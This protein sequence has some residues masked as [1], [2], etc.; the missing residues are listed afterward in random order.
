MDWRQ[1]ARRR[2]PII[3]RF[4]SESV[5]DWIILLDAS[6]SMAVHGAAK[7]QAAVQ[8]AA[9]LS[10]ALLELGHRVGL[11]AFGGRVLSEFPRGRGQHHYAALARYLHR[12]SPRA[13]ARGPNSVFVRGTCTAPLRSLPSAISWRTTR[14]VATS[15]FCSSAAPHYTHCRCSD[16]PR[17][18][19]GW[20]ATSTSWTPRA[21]RGCS[22]APADAQAN[23]LAAG[24][25]AAMTARLR[26]SACAQRHRLHRLEYRA[27][28]AHAASTPDSGARHLLSLV[29]PV[30]L[31]GSCCCRLFDGCIAEDHSNARCPCPAW[32]SGGTRL[33]AVPPQGN[34][35]LPTPRGGAVRC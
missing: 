2:R 14:C 34:A 17:P 19:C 26:S 13:P 20:R 35:G 7:W 31:L 16:S 11:L 9:A 21:A 10:F 30:W 28:V 25:R 32:I 18:N 5:S 24:E 29:T 6:S 4:E 23:A 22:R 27:A 12:C 15:A 3:R 33:Q 1:T 8:V